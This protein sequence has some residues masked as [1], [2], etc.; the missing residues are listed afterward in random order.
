MNKKVNLTMNEV[1]NQ[2]KQSEI[3]LLLPERLRKERKK[4]GWSMQKVSDLLNIKRQTYNGYEAPPDRAYH[5]AP[6]FDVLIKLADLFQ[7]SS[8]YLIGL[9]DN[10]AP[11]NSSVDVF[12]LLDQAESIDKNTREYITAML[13]KAAKENRDTVSA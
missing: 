6:S 9:T 1:L 2:T 10:P 7:V 11:F 3:K 4:L 12:A 8:D 5:R 13:K